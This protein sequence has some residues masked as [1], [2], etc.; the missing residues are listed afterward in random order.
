MRQYKGFN[1]AYPLILA[2]LR[3]EGLVSAPR[4]KATKEI[5]GYSFR[6]N[7]SRRN[8]LV[9]SVRRLSHKYLIAEWLW[10]YFGRN[11]VNS[12]V[13]FNKNL[14]QFSDDGVQFNGAY[15]PQ[16][17]EQWPYIVKTLTDDHESRQAVLTMWRPRPAQSK[18][19]PCTVAMQFIRRDGRLNMIVTMRSNDAWLGLPYDVFTF[20]QLQMCMAIQ[21]GIQP[22]W[23]QHQVGSMHIYEE[24]FTKSDLLLGEVAGQTVEDYAKIE[25]LEISGV[26]EKIPMPLESMYLTI[27]GHKGQNLDFPFVDEPAEFADMFSDDPEAQT[28]LGALLDYPLGRLKAIR[29]FE[30]R[31]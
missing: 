31:G 30:R 26:V 11:D 16:V 28:W 20:T 12:I 9:S 18:D 10:V 6:L 13:P 23:Y 1:Q 22:G 5:L 25:E 2:D 27:A 24:H 3:D 8:T 21:L 29:E 7:N 19:I 4:G 15:G 14:L 17:L